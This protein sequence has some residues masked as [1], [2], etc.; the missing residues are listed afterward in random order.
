MPPMISQIS[1]VVLNVTDLARSLAFYRDALGFELLAAG[2][3][4]LGREEIELRPTDGRP[5]PRP[6]AANDPWF[7]HFAIAVSDM[8][9]AHAHLR[10]FNLEPISSHGPQLLP[11]STGSVT[12]FKFRDPD[13]HP[14]ELSYIPGSPWLAAPPSASPFLGVDHTA[15]AAIDLTA[16]VA[17]Y[18]SLGMTVSGRYLNQ[19][20]E[21]DRL[22]GLPGVELDIVALAASD[23]GP[24]IE[25]L[26]Y[27][28]PPSS[29]PMA[30]QAGDVAGTVTVLTAREPF[31]GPSVDLHD[32]TGHRLRIAASST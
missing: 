20:P 4:R 26:H 32:P 3:L 19:G 21:Q 12:A 18:E 14:L 31:A 16:G 27:R 25:L 11:A 9:A 17:F 30:R 13:G 1:R 7:Q 29:A 5:Y 15:L 23:E 8:A 10:Q 22:D 28:S 6:R 2:R 24:H